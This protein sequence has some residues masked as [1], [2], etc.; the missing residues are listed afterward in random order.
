MNTE[1]EIE[2]EEEEKQEQKQE[3]KQETEQNFAQSNDRCM[4]AHPPLFS[5][6][7]L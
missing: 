2:V 4:G 5:A 3:Q 1:E 6:L 7:S